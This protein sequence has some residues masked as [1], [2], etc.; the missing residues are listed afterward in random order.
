[1]YKSTVRYSL[2]ACNSHTQ[3]FKVCWLSGLG[4]VII[5][6]TRQTSPK[7]LTKLG[8][9]S[10]LWPP[11]PPPLRLSVDRMLTSRTLSE[12]NT[13]L[14]RPTNLSVITPVHYQH[15][16]AVI[17]KRTALFGLQLCHIIYIYIYI[18]SPPP[19]S[20]H[21]LC[22]LRGPPSWAWQECNRLLRLG[23]P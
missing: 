13:W 21:V 14:P 20:P 7:L 4:D 17:S 18:S 23:R 6:V 22:G 5:A 15:T 8:F 3:P 10:F 12:T 1:M 9:Q 2:V 19:M 11:L 16:T